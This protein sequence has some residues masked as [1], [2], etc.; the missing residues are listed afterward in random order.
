MTAAVDFDAATL[1]G[2]GFASAP[3]PLPPPRIIDAT[4]VPMEAPVTAGP[5]GLR[6]VA[7]APP[8]ASQSNAQTSAVTSSS[9]ARSASAARPGA[10]HGT[11]DTPSPTSLGPVATR[12]AVGQTDDPRSQGTAAKRSLTAQGTTQDARSPATFGSTATRM[13]PAQTTTR[14]SGSLNATAIAL[15]TGRAP[16]PPPPVAAAAR[17]AVA[18]TSYHELAVVEQPED[19]DGQVTFTSHA[20]R[21]AAYEADLI[22]EAAREAVVEHLA[23]ERAP[24]LA[25]AKKKKRPRANWVEK[26]PKR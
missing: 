11:Q 7:I 2:S 6:A 19:Y 13:A 12:S 17:I 14:G 9:A 26:N 4:P 3:E 20:A 5:R 18:N 24:V 1:E 21:Y 22:S 23:T 16:P 10:A 15:T 25:A 8:V